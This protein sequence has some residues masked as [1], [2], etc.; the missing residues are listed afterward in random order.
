VTTL[1]TAEAIVEAYGPPLA[2]FAPATFHHVSA[3]S[4]AWSYGVPGARV[5]PLGMGNFTVHP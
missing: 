4:R 2:R 5:T 1:G 3:G